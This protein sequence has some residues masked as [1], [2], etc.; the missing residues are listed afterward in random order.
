MLGSY[1]IIDS[2]G[3]IYEKTHKYLENNGYIV[4][5]INCNESGNDYKYNPL[6]HIRNN[7]ERDKL[8]IYEKGLKSIIAEKDYYFNN[9]KW[10]EL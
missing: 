3:E 6:N 9:E 5:T 4:K 10:K 7:L 8:L 1:V 2:W